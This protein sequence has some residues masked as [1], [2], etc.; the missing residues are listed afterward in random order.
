M[1]QPTDDLAA[2]RWLDETCTGEFGTVG[3]LVP[4]H[5][6]AVARVHPPEQGE[7]W[8]GR[9]RRLF[10]TV[11]EVAVRHTTTPDHAYFGLWDGYGL[12]GGSMNVYYQPTKDPVALARQAA[13]RRRMRLESARQQTEMRAQLDQLPAFT[14]PNRRYYLLRGA[15]AGVTELRE[16]THDPWH[17]PDLWWPADQAWSIASD[18]DFWSL[19]V[20][21]TEAFV[22]DLRAAATTVVEDVALTD[23]FE[24]ED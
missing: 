3:C 7:R 17:E 4:S 6:D 15:V 5:F 14:R 11:A 9:Y 19:Y 22:D 12:E 13:E 24:I 18:V 1:L 2:T 21:G 8:D 23:R 20:G 10:A 16:P